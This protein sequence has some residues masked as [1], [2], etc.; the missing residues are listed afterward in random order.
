MSSISL[1]SFKNIAGTSQSIGYVT[2]DA[3]GNLQKTAAHRH[4]TG[5]NITPQASK[6][7][8]YIRTTLYNTIRQAVVG[9]AEKANPRQEAFLKATARKLGISFTGDGNEIGRDTVVSNKPLDRRTLRSVLH[10]TDIRLNEQD[11]EKTNENRAPGEAQATRTTKPADLPKGDRAIA[12]KFNPDSAA[13]KKLSAADQKAIL[14]GLQKLADSSSYSSVEVSVG[15]KSVWLSKADTDFCTVE[16]PDGKSFAVSDP[17]KL[18]NALADK[19]LENPSKA[20]KEALEAALDH[21]KVSPFCLRGPSATKARD[22]AQKVL[23]S[24]CG[25]GTKLGGPNGLKENDL[26]TVSP[27]SMHKL[28]RAVLRGDVDDAATLRMALETYQAPDM[29]NSEEVLKL[30]EQ[31]E[32]AD[33]EQQEQVKTLQA[34]PKKEPTSIFSAL[35]SKLSGL[36]SFNKQPKPEPVKVSAQ[37][38]KSMMAD[39]IHDENTVEMDRLNGKPGKQLAYSIGKHTATLAALLCNPDCEA[40]KELPEEY[41]S[42]VKDLLEDI[43]SDETLASKCK[44][45]NEAKLKTD[46]DLALSSTALDGKL[47]E[48]SEKISQQTQKQ[49][50]RLQAVIKNSFAAMLQGKTVDM[51]GF[52]ARLDSAAEFL[53]DGTM[54]EAKE[55]DIYDRAAQLV[56]V[57]DDIRAA[58]EDLIQALYPNDPQAQSEAPRLSEEDLHAQALTEL[59]SRLKA[60]A[61]KPHTDSAPTEAVPVKDIVAKSGY[62]NLPEMMRA[63]GMSQSDIDRAENPPPEPSKT[64]ILAGREVKNANYAREVEQHK[65]DMAKWK[66]A[67]LELSQKALEKLCQ[68]AAVDLNTGYGAFMLKA[69]NTYFKDMPVDDQRNMLAAGI[70]YAPSKEQMEKDGINE[71]VALLGATLKGAGPIMQKMLQGL[72]ST[73]CDPAF[74]TALKDMKSKLAPIPD[75]IVKANLFD[76]VQRSNGKIEKIEVTK[77]LGAASVGQAFF[78]TV[79]LAEK[80]P[81]TGAN[82]TKDVVVKMLRPDA[83]QRAKRETEIFRNAASQVNGMAVTFEGQLA[84]IMD[85][86]DL[87]IEAENTKAGAVYDKG[88]NEVQSAKVLDLIPPTRYTLVQERAPG[89]TVDDLCEKIREDMASA[90]EPF[91][92]KVPVMENGEPVLDE[93]GQPK[94]ETKLRENAPGKTVGETT[95]QFVQTYK[96]LCELYS[97][98]L[99]QQRRLVTLAEK[100]CTQ[101]IYD[102]GFYH[103]DLHAGNIMVDDAF[104]KDENG[105]LVIDAETGLP[106]MEGNGGLTV[107][108]FGNA[109]KL[110]SDQ[111]KAV[112][113]MMSAASVK[114]TN[115]FMAGF[116]ALMTA[117]GQKDFDKLTNVIHDKIHNILNL[118]TAGDSGMR[119]AAI[120]QEL[121]K[122]GFELPGPIFKFSQCQMRLQGTIEEMNTMLADIHKAMEEFRSVSPSLLGSTDGKNSAFSSYLD[123]SYDVLSN[124]VLNRK[125]G[126][127]ED[128]AGSYKYPLAAIKRR[129]DWRDG[130]NIPEKPGPEPSANDKVAHALWKKAND[131]RA[132]YDK[133]VNDRKALEP[134]KGACKYSKLNMMYDR[135]KYFTPKEVVVG[136]LSGTMGM[137]GTRAEQIELIGNTVKDLAAETGNQEI[138]KLFEK[139]KTSSNEQLDASDEEI[140]K[141]GK[142]KS[143]AAKKARELNSIRTNLG[144][145]LDRLEN[146]AKLDEFIAAQ[147]KTVLDKKRDGLADKGLNPEQIEKEIENF[148]NA[149]DGLKKEIREWLQL[150]ENYFQNANNLFALANHANMMRD[151]LKV[152]LAKLEKRMNDPSLTDQERASAKAQLDMLNKQIADAEKDAAGPLADFKKEYGDLDQDPFFR[153]YT[154][155]SSPFEFDT[156]GELCPLYDD[157]ETARTVVDTFE[158]EFGSRESLQSALDKAKADEEVIQKKVDD[159]K[160]DR[161]LENG[162]C[163]KAGQAAEEF[164]ALYEKLM[165]ER[166]EKTGQ[167]IEKFEVGGH[168]RSTETFFDAIGTVIGQNV[169]ASFTKVGVIGGIVTHIKS[170][171][172]QAPV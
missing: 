10:Q 86:L 17:S 80:D 87:R 29:I 24:L 35:G 57:E 66:K 108:D 167:A 6:T 145:Y 23:L 31:F 106:S 51:E 169:F 89:R 49:F 71:G 22:A 120:L 83:E 76:M 124:Q 113:Q 158:K 42:V 60:E 110:T 105:N 21:V 159:L 3:K 20:G 16:L 137:R 8:Q 74:K 1:N 32:H 170:K 19:I 150:R 81:K 125:G 99:V 18:K 93:K 88:G 56:Q 33:A 115:R 30:V 78:C 116:R 147:Q 114:D 26:Q 128:I 94:T 36:F 122:M 121:Q 13:F 130:K 101:G 134:P 64:K 9:T 163:D 69:M 102:S 127:S 112:V 73:N 58:E 149:D 164:G 152:D 133:F 91:Y 79:T 141:L 53:R 27:S 44:P 97:T 142:E 107:I 140:A 103:G 111:Q 75:N 168:K 39:I 77:S 104:K 157:L 117:Q 131:E 148:R 118:G 146:Q 82:L 166:M 68:D 43:A 5:R 63:A 54:K 70:R 67:R 2:T 129:I 100:W 48:A 172:E 155:L 46:L 144:T 40:L 136:V 96:K 151:G 59:E 14:R 62:K 7:D 139:A 123:N 11:V 41:R 153:L 119:I 55:T 25:P 162:P 160:R 45:G 85:E 161:C 143:A 154:T 4:M 61:E 72:A 50:V 34:A 109:T 135:T 37:D 90:L 38:V 84:S 92:E 12:D 65:T 28:A 15:G 95:Q 52:G 47:A 98:T 132:L 126:D 165:V 138:L 171:K 156:N